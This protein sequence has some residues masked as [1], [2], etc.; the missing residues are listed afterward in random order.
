[1]PKTKGEVQDELI[2][3]FGV[4]ITGSRFYE[5][6]GR[7]GSF[8]SDPAQYLPALRE[9]HAAM[10]RLLDS[11]GGGFSAGEELNRPLH[12]ALA[13]IYRDTAPGSTGGLLKGRFSKLLTSVLQANER[14]SGFHAGV[15][16]SQTD[17][18]IGLS[19]SRF[20]WLLKNR[21]PFK[22]VGASYEHGENSHRIQ[23]YLISKMT[24]LQNPVAEIYEKLTGWG[25]KEVYKPFGRKIYMWEFLVDRD[26]IPSNVSLP[27][28]TD[29]Q[30]DFRAPS[31]VNRFLKNGQY[32]ELYLLEAVL[33]H[34]WAKR[35]DEGG[36]L[37]YYC[38][39]R[40]I[41]I[42]KLSSQEVEK[43]LMGEKSV[44]QRLD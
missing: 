3:W 36:A 34:R 6:Y 37:A 13:R 18:L 33:S 4:K 7:I 43:I 25:T 42:N 41:D 22:D 16:E 28:K 15:G 1:M 19:G 24:T 5:D 31:N 32:P 30:M 26:G 14:A 20:N 21:R 2:E 38:R 23:W 10:E 12:K 8:L 27:I 9:L 11:R 40:G 17:I 39:K 35:Q 29:S 44:I